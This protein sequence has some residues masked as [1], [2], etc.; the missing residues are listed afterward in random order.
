MFNPFADEST[1]LLEAL[2]GEVVEEP[3]P[4][5]RLEE[6]QQ[7]LSGVEHRL[8]VF[9]AHVEAILALQGIG[10]GIAESFSFIYGGLP[11]EA[12]AARELVEKTID[13]TNGR[14]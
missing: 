1:A 6:Y 4:A 11:Y 8:E 5:A 13:D 2:I 12:E 10:I 3:P 7:R 9:D 14:N